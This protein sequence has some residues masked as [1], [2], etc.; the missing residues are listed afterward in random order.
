MKKILFVILCLTLILS[1]CAM[2]KAWKSIPPPGG[3]DQCHFVEIGSD[4]RAINRPVTIN[5]E[6]GRYSWQKPQSVLPPENSP[7]DDRKVQELRC[8]RCHK[9]PD[10]KHIDYQGMYHH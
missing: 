9:G 3:C 1:G 10:R 6:M 2:I 5:D 7:M 4:W 8:F